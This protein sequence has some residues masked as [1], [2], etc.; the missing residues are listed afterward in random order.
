MVNFKKKSFLININSEL[1]LNNY[2][3][4]QYKKQLIMFG[5]FIEN[6]PEF[7]F[8]LLKEFFPLLNSYLPHESRLSILLPYYIALQGKQMEMKMFEKSYFKYFYENEFLKKFYFFILN[9]LFSISQKNI[10]Q[11]FFINLILYFRG[12]RTFI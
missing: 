10:S 7:K 5:R 9:I 11:L 3:P 6:L 4:T 2:F 8:I 12:T 1:S